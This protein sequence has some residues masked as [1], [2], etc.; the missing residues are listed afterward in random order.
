MRA[1]RCLPLIVLA[2]LA[3]LNASSVAHPSIAPVVR[4]PVAGPLLLAHHGGRRHRD[5]APLVTRQPA[6]E[7]V[8]AAG[9]AIFSASAGGSPQPRVRWE[10]SGNHGRSWSVISGVRARTLSFSALPTENGYEYRAIFANRAGSATTRPATL[11]VSTP[12]PPT[13]APTTPPPSAS[14][15]SVS[16]Q[17]ASASVETGASVSFSATATANPSPTEQWQLSTDGGNDWSDVVGATS[18]TY[19][20]TASSGENGYEYRALFTNTAGSATSAAATLN[21]TNPAPAAPQITLQPSDQ[22]VID[23]DVASFTASA[24]GY[25][26]PTVQWQ[27]SLNGGE[28]WSNAPGA[29]TNGTYTFTADMSQNTN[30]YRAVFTNSVTSATTQ[31]A[32]LAVTPQQSGNWSGYYTYGATFTSVSGD[33]TVPT[34]TCG[35]Q[36]AYSSQWIGIDGAIG[37]SDTVEQDGTEADCSGGSSTT[38]SYGAWYEMY[39]DRQDGF[40]Y[41]SE[42][43][44]TDCDPDPNCTVS[45]NDSMSAQVSVNDSHWT[46][47]IDD[48]TAGW[49]FTTTI[50]SPTPTPAQ[51]SA[52]WIVERPDIGSRNLPALADFA[53]TTFTDASATAGASGSISAFSYAPI[54]MVSND[55]SATL[56]TPGAL[57]ADGTSFTATWVG[58][59]P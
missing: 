26:A 12:P 2:L 36:P 6:S 11:T 8:T 52:E 49:T 23:G 38:A 16:T 17:P 27:V 55:G 25:P 59:G 43:E 57:S 5:R 24:S 42:V 48:L 18:T 40:L 46:L 28:N 56:S 45:A 1:R 50:D 32:A 4:A 29:A 19:A 33:W 14:I 58:S 34:L 22:T 9:R 44:L 35:S 51:S 13:P 20:F 15:P 37:S 39:G 53:S 10:R 30:E 31:A 3:A 7:S 21:V 41:Y 47:A 54:D